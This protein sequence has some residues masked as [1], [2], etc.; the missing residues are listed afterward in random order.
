M[1]LVWEYYWT[2]GG[3]LLTALA[4]ADHAHDDGTGVRPSVAFMAR[5]TRQSERTIQMH[6]ASMRRT[7]WLLTVQHATGGRGRTTEYR[8]NPAWIANPE[9][10]AP[11]SNAPQRAQSETE[12]GANGG[13]KGCKAIAPQSLRTVIEP[14][15]TR[16]A[17]LRG[18][19]PAND[20]LKWPLV[21]GGPLR[22][23]A[24]QV[25]Q[26]C[27]LAARQDVLDEIAGLADR[28]NVRSP[29]G[30][31]RSL[32][33]RVKRG[34]FIPAAAMEYRRRLESVSAAVLARTADERQREQQST[35]LARER[36]RERLALLRQQLSG[37]PPPQ[38]SEVT[39]MEPITIRISD[40]TA[41]SHAGMSLLCNEDQVE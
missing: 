20:E 33:K 1:S 3:E 41:R 30:L 21:L 16:E 14:T 31:L 8:I 32:V 12:K 10:I 29:I 15:T 25:L 26:D 24:L 4:Y 28:N 2:G 18:A 38:Q 22:T 37:H 36:A 6:L 13:I 27:P 9:K 23:S 7:G 17:S 19:G 35:P 11:F 40:E 5:K 34:Q 39:A